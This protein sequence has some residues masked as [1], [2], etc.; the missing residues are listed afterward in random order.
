MLARHGLTV[1]QL[2]RFVAGTDVLS[3]QSDGTTIAGQYA[4]EGITL[5][6]AS[7]ERINGWAAVLQGFGDSEGGVRPKLFIHRRCGRLV[8][9]LPALQHDPSRPEDVLKVDAD[10]DGVGGD[11][12]A[13]AL[14]Y[15]VATKSRG[16]TQRKLRG[17]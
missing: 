4:R 13:D 12:A 6:P 9:T 3:R 2:R 16:V 11:D 8:E 10:E 5:R 1:E 14:R 17:L 7:M 15:M